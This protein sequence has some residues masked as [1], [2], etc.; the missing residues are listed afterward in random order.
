[1][2]IK[3]HVPLCEYTTFKVGGPADFFVSVNTVEELRKALAWAHTKNLP[4]FI[5]GG[6]SNI[7]FPDDGYRGLVV[8]MQLKGICFEE[9]GE[10]ILLKASA[11]EIW[12]V[13]VAETVTRGLWGLENLSLIPGSVGATPVQNVGAYGVEVSNVIKQVEVFD[14]SSESITSLSN[15]ECLFAYRN[16]LFKTDLGRKYIIT[17]VTYELSKKARPQLAYKDL[18]KRFGHYK[19]I[20]TIDEVRSAI[21]AIRQGKF[22]DLNRYGT[23]G[24]FFH[25][26]II[27]KE[28]YDD[29]RIS[30]PDLPSFSMEGGYV[31]IVLSW[32]LDKIL[33]L[34]GVRRSNVGTH[35][36]HALVI[37][38]Y[39]G[40]HSSDIKAFA[41]YVSEK[42]FDATGIVIVPEVKIVEN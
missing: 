19:N 9:Q 21:I 11:G 15:E 1:M 31:K 35:D 20:P 23:A 7:L 10:R 34:K 22:P 13:L 37:V 29:L 2:Y 17:S 32:F 38:N 24:S 25:S 40:A 36:K 14:V 4:Y 8:H 28:A 39:G 16:S 5:L 12:D 33:N 18:Q 6:G 27:S 42:V 26:P 41:N 3:E 30:F